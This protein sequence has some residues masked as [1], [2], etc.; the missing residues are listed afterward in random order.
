[1]SG[2]NKLGSSSFPPGFEYSL[3]L[4]T[5]FLEYRV[6]LPSSVA[7]DL[8]KSSM[9][10]GIDNVIADIGLR[11]HS[12]FILAYNSDA[13]EPPVDE[14]AGAG[15]LAPLLSLR[16][17]ISVSLGVPTLIEADRSLKKV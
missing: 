2:S 15:N 17:S 9:S 1:M 14:I 12:L 6:S 11:D 8:T 10:S 16:S 13:S 3:L 7:N 4:L 5:M